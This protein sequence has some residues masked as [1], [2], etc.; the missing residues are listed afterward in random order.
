MGVKIRRQRIYDSNNKTSDKYLSINIKEIQEL[1]VECEIEFSGFVMMKNFFGSNTNLCP[2]N[3][4][5][6]E[7]IS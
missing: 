3:L 7:K 2:F 1:V 4:I 6:R 5:R